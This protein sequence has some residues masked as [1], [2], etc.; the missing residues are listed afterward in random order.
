[1]SSQIC[2]RCSID[3]TV[4]GVRFDRSGECNYCKMHDELDRAYPLNEK[5]QKKF[6]LLIEAIRKN[7]RNK[8]Y[9]CIVGIVYILFIF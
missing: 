3:S 2:S 9:D 8:P 5:G 7:G 6:E 1:M 4:A